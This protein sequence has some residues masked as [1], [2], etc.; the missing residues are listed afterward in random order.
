M[1]LENALASII[2]LPYNAWKYT[3]DA[4]KCILIGDFKD[5]DCGGFILPF[6]RIGKNG[7]IAAGAIVTKDVPGNVMIAGVSIV[8]KNIR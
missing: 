6:E 3:E 1:S 5:I 2:V 4:I 8:K 7:V